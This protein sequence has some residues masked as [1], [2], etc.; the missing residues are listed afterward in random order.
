MKA[1]LKRAAAL[2]YN[3]NGII[4]NL[5]NLGTESLPYRMSQ[6]NRVHTEGHYFLYKFDVP[7]T[8]IP[9]LHTE[10]KRDV[11]IV[12]KQ[13]FKVETPEYIPCT[14]EE[15]LQPPV[16][17]QEVQEMIKI[18]QEKQEKESRE[19]KHFRK[20]SGITYYPFQR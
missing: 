15:E 5:E 1:A 20:K 8:S 14:L 17:R 7:P 3:Q 4:R 19:K 13:I 6:H 9:F 16:Y 18:S 11:D 2:I 12:S 10:Y